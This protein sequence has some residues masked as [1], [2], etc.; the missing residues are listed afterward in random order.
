MTFGIGSHT[1]PGRFFASQE[2]K[3][4]MAYLIRNYDIKLEDEAEG[5]P[6]NIVTD[7]RVRPDPTKRVLMKR[8]ASEKVE[9]IN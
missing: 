5:R 2:I 8:R 7:Y 9:V 4:V 1:C 3:L 6:E